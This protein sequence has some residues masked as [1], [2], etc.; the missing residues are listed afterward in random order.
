MRLSVRGLRGQILA[1][2]V[3][4]TLVILLVVAF[5][6]F[7]AYSRVTE[8][9]VM[10][11]NRELTRLLAGQMGLEL[12]DYADR[13]TL[14]ADGRQRAPGE[15]PMPWLPYLDGHLSFLHDFDSG[16]IV[17]DES[18][19]VIAADPRRL[20]ILG[21][22]WSD[23][24]HFRRVQTQPVP[25]LLS[26]METDG[27]EG[28]PVVAVAVPR[29][30][31]EG[32]IEE[33]L[34]GLFAVQPHTGSAFYRSL[35]RLDLRMESR[36]YLVDSRGRAIYHHD[37]GRV[38]SDVSDQAAVQAVQAGLVGAWR[39]FDG[40]S[41]EIVAS[42]A[43]IPHTLVSLVEEESWTDLRRISLG[44]GRVLV[45][46]LLFAVLVPATIVSIA[47]RRI[48]RPIKNL[49]IR[50][51]AISRGELSQIVDVPQ[52]S[53]LAELAQAF[54]RMSSRLESFYADLESRVD[55][56]TRE[57]SAM[58]EIAGVVS[59]SLDLDDIL[60]AALDK[61]LELMHMGAG[62]AYEL[63]PGTD[64][65]RLIAQRGLP[66]E[67]LSQRPEISL[68]AFVPHESL[69][70]GAQVWTQDRYPRRGLWRALARENWKQIVLVPL[71][72]R[73]ELI[74]LL[75]LRAR[76]PRDLGE[77]ELALLTGIG[78]QVGIALENARLYREA[79][80]LAVMAERNRLA[81]DLHD[82]VT[83]T[84]FTV[85]LLAGVIPT[86][87]EE[88]PE[89]AQFHLEELARL[90][91]SALNEM[92]ALLLE[93][94][95]AALAQTPLE[96]LLARL[97]EST[98]GSARMPVHVS[99]DSGL[100]IPPRVRVALYRIAQEAINNVVKHSGADQAW[101]RLRRRVANGSPGVELMVRDD[102]QGFDPSVA[103]EGRLGLSIIHERASDIQATLTVQSAPGG[104]TTV[105]ILW[106]AQ[107]S[108]QEQQVPDVAVSGQRR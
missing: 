100:D 40:D 94:R 62:T 66:S 101:I 42:Y 49:T 102:G 56:R 33:I 19:S 14:L 106:F 58:N 26:D 29:L 31:N 38:G 11:R 72:R 93:L 88:N 71:V 105:R 98:A 99:A 9:L 37:P 53:E 64:T 3:L 18:G 48:T 87:Y 68:S 30:D 82:S 107:E 92:R 60:A 89:E 95:P 65:L 63:E 76:N 90:T 46:I 12:A 78:S 21:Q 57:L 16:V 39:G 25:L 27:P 96:E 108:P 50:A 77:Q 35:V 73:G 24:S 43:P 13:L 28:T 104:G 34:I 84:I 54:N 103:Q 67:A 97:G 80:A 44:Y 86:L 85:N 1:W 6:S 17:L 22:D 10:D 36:V 51:D 41:E 2:S 75:N 32:Q 61:V 70:E 91:R 52:G 59:Q 5:F 81:Q 7:W 45:A 8:V 79:G 47:I 20:D 74:G 4:P 69:A 55:A 83:Q 15:T 23:R